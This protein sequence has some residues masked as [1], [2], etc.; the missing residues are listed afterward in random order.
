MLLI[1]LFV[2][3]MLK[4]TDPDDPDPGVESDPV[5]YRYLYGQWDRSFA[6]DVF[7]VERVVPPEEGREAKT[8]SSSNNG[9]PIC[10]VTI[11]LQSKNIAASQ[12][13]S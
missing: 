7:I 6:G 5:P 4:I 1:T 9:I 2:P 10:P 13:I 3:V 12:K 8:G 11:L